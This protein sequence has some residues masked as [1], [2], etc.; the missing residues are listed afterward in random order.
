MSV[1]GPPT[2]ADLVD[3]LV[4]QSLLVVTEDGGTARFRAL[5]TIREYAAARLARSSGEE[6]AAADAQRDV[7]SGTETRS[8]STSSETVAGPSLAGVPKSGSLSRVMAY[9]P[10][11]R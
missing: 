4:E 6:E 8:P 9:L 3:A 5:E 10:S 11:S 2:V 7:P 1:L